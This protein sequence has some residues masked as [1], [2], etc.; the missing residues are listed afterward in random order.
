M[1]LKEQT[2]DT[3]FTDF[4]GERPRQSVESVSI[5]LGVEAAW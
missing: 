5:A 2:G 1:N 4:H 3:N